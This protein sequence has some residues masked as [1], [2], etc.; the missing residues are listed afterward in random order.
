MT[1][2]LGQI[3][4][5][6][7]NFAAKGWANC[8]GQLMSIQQNAALFSILGTTYGGNGIQTFALP[9]LR[10]RVPI[11]WGQG[12]G[13]SDYVLGEQSGA[14]SVTVLANQLPLHNHAFNANNALATSG[15][16][17]GN[18]LGQGGLDAGANVSIYAGG[19][20]NAVMAASALAPTGGTQPISIIQPYSVINYCVALNG[21]FPSRN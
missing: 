11:S 4:G 8:A 13:L 18:Y 17:N 20:S 2:F 9:D 1:P 10:G 7:F 15:S 14:Q 6:G 3:T 16:P 5:F 12:P 19:G 21:I